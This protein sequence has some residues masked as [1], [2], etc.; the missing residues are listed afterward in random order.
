MGES[1]GGVQPRDRWYCG[2]PVDRRAYVVD[3]IRA[4]RG[5]QGHV[6]RAERRTFAG[7]TV[8]YEGPVSL[9]VSS[10]VL[11][12]AQIE[13]MRERWA[14]VAGIEHPNLARP[15]E[16][17]AG[18]GLFRTDPPPGSDDDVLYMSAA[19][20]DGPGLRGAAPL[21]PAGAVALAADLAA[22]LAALHAHGVLHRDV[23][24][25]NVV[26]DARR[27]GGADRL[28]LVAARRRHGH[29]DGGRGARLHRPGAAPRGRHRGDGPLGARDGDRVRPARPPA[30]HDGPPGAGGRAGGGA[31]RRR[32]PAGRGAAADRHDRRRSGRAAPRPLPLGGGAAGLPRPPVAP[33]AGGGG[34]ARCR[35]PGGGGAGRVHDAGRRRR[36]DAGRRGGARRARRQPGRGRPRAAPV[37][38]GGRTAPGRAGPRRS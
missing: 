10:E 6:L 22:G 38:A 11:T 31:R 28:R 26:L 30:G 14:S 3:D 24:P 36:R 2:P 13:R 29:D 1:E 32:R 35:G 8:G 7:D 15:L 25:G 17:F 20:V 34:R 18:P 27:P 16:L 12:A 5:G 21:A 37:H 4:M 9:K 33:P 23:H 19:W